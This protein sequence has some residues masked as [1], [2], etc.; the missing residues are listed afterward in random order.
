MSNPHTN[1]KLRGFETALS[2]RP[3]KLRLTESEMVKAVRMMNHGKVRITHV[4]LRNR[5]RDKAHPFTAVIWRR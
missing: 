4:V 3:R 5:R 2:S 1:R